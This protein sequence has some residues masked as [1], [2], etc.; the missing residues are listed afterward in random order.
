M[1]KL[2]FITTNKYKVAEIGAVLKDYGIEIKQVIIDYPEDKEANMEE[3]CKKA[4]KDLANKFKKP[5]IVEDTGFFFHAYKNFPGSH[6]KFIINSIGFDGIFRLLKGKNRGFT[7]RT[8]IGYCEPGKKPK[9]FSG[10]LD[11]KVITK[12]IAPHVDTMPYNHIIIPDGYKKTLAEMNLTERNLVLH[13]AKAARKLGAF[14]K[15][16]YENA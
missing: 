1:N 6:P 2:I 12:V 3:V 16:K 10:E 5:L 15:K 8:V 4:A 7:S 9:L 13:R 11:G 14:L